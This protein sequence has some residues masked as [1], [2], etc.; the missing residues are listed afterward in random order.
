MLGPKRGLTEP[1]SLFFKNLV[2]EKE[3]KT[4][5]HIFVKKLIT[6]PN[7]SYSA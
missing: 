7:V 4:T 1:T 6:F 3:L 2:K 5:D